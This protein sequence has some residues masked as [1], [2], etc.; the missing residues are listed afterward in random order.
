[1]RYN[2]FRQFLRESSEGEKFEDK[3]YYLVDGVTDSELRVRIVGHTNGG[4][5]RVSCDAIFDQPVQRKIQKDE[6]GNEFFRLN[7]KFKVYA[8]DLDASYSNGRRRKQEEDSETLNERAFRRMEREMERR[9]IEGI[10]MLVEDILEEPDFD[11]DEEIDFAQDDAIANERRMNV[12]APAYSEDVVNSNWEHEA[13]VADAEV[14]PVRI[15]NMR[16]S[17]MLPVQLSEITVDIPAGLTDNAAI[18]RAVV[19]QAV[20]QGI[21]K[22]P[23][24]ADGATLVSYD[25]EDVDT[26]DIDWDNEEGGISSNI[27]R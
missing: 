4:F 7:N 24:D 17:G 27:Y 10:S 1:M 9:G 3:S 21:F 18:Q 14:T 6:E 13:D 25:S 23:W 20:R 8:T 22:S 16:W 2:P 19:A 12:S 5:V 11:E 26:P 15:Y